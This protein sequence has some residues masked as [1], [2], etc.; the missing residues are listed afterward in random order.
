MPSRFFYPQGLGEGVTPSNLPVMRRR[1]INPD[2]GNTLLSRQ[3]WIF[4]CVNFLFMLLFSLSV[5]LYFCPAPIFSLSPLLC[6]LQFSPL[7]WE[8]LPAV[9]QKERFCKIYLDIFHLLSNHSPLLFTPS[10]SFSFESL[11]SCSLIFHP[12]DSL[13]CSKWFASLISPPTCHSRF[14]SASLT[15]HL[16]IHL[17]GS[18]IVC[19]FPWLWTRVSLFLSEDLGTL[20]SS[21][22][23]DRICSQAAAVEADSSAALLPRQLPHRRQRFPRAKRQWLAAR[24]CSLCKNQCRCLVLFQNSCEMWFLSIDEETESHN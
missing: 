9:S 16:C 5:F 21:K 13:C 14:L 10:L 8:F 18:L 1:S 2:R 24:M 11:S 3:C 4:L 23:P 6:P 17:P 22:Q 20:F 15:L 7:Q 12:G 19:Q